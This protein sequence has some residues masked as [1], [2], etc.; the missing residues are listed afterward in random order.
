MLNLVQL[1]GTLKEDPELFDGRS[2]SL[3]AEFTVVNNTVRYDR[4]LGPVLDP[5]FVRV[6]AWEDAAEVA[7]RLGKGTVVLVTGQLTQQ[8]VTDRAGKRDRKTKVQALTVQVVKTPAADR[9]LASASGDDEYP[10]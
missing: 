9:V 8:E 10:G 2:G 6:I 3:R 7:A 5:L 1:G 4:S